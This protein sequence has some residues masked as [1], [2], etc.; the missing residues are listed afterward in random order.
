MDKETLRSTR[1]QLW[2]SS[3][4][5]RGFRRGAM[6][7]GAWVVVCGVFPAVFRE[8]VF[9][10]LIKPARLIYKYINIKA[11]LLLYFYIYEYKYKSIKDI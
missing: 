11:F 3:V 9:E 6:L 8:T 7:S 5:T 2:L 4:N 1:T 10:E